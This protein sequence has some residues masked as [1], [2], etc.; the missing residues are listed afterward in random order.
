MKIIPFLSK[1]SFFKF[2]TSLYLILVCF[3]CSNDDNYDRNCNF[4]LD[5]GIQAS[6][7]L[8]L[9]QYN[10]LTFANNPVSVPNEGYGGLFVNNTGLGFV[11]FDAADPN[12]PF[13]GCSYLIIDGATAV[14]P[15]ES[16]DGS[17]LNCNQI[18]RYSLLTGQPLQNPELR[19][20]LKPYFVERIGNEL[21]IS[22]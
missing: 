4:L 16:R 17:D 9:A 20:S 12:I 2:F 13:G 18:N 22:N 1:L 3:T 15:T 21:F 7:N 19:C 14:T 8:N 6:L 11:A 5:V 10:Q